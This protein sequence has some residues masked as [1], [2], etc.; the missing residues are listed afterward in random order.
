MPVGVDATEFRLHLGIRENR[1]Y[2]E[3]RDF[4]GV[5]LDRVI[6][7]I[8]PFR[9]IVRDYFLICESY[10]QAIKRLTPSQ[11]EAI[12]MG[13]RGLHDDGARMLMEC[14][15]EKVEMDFKTARRLF[16]LICVLQIRG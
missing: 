2:L 7:S 15:A 12:D 1:L 16:T 11:I 13:R 4:S 5:V 3:I 14:L 10:Y 9:S 8:T 6:L